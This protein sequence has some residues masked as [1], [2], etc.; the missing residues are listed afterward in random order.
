MLS[1]GVEKIFVHSGAGG[2]V[3][4]P[5]FE[6][7]F[8]DYGGAPR[9]LVPAMAVFTELLGEKPTSA[10]YRRLGESGH[11][12]AFETGKKSVA[13]VWQEEEGG[14]IA[15]AA[16]A[17]VECLDLMGR[18]L[19]A[20]PVKLST[21]PVYLVGAAGKAKGLLDSLRLAAPKP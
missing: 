20:K 17:D 3:N 19:A 2:K 6:C 11:A 12:A 16:G 4:D 10:G 5:N 8:F 1:H 7:A 9:K 15:I 14:D 21:S 18:K 13:V